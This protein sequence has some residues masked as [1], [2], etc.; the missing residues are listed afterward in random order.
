M[1]RDAPC[2]SGNMAFRRDVE[3]L[4]VDY[5]FARRHE[6]IHIARRV[7]ASVH[8]RGGR[9]LKLD[10]YVN[11]QEVYV[12]IELDRALHKASQ[13]LRERCFMDR[14]N[15]DN[16]EK[17]D[18]VV[19]A[20]GGRGNAEV[21]STLESTET[22]SMVPC[23]KRNS[24]DNSNAFDYSGESGKSDDSLE[25]EQW[26]YFDDAEPPPANTNVNM[27]PGAE[28]DMTETDTSSCSENHTGSFHPNA[29]FKDTSKKRAP[30]HRLMMNSS[31]AGSATKFA[32]SSTWLIDFF[33]HETSWEEM[34]LAVAD[35]KEV[36]GHCAIAPSSCSPGT[37]SSPGERAQA[38]L[39]DWASV[40]RQIF[41]EIHQGRR[42]A[43]EQ[44]RDR[45]ARLE[46]IGFV[47][48]YDEFHWTQR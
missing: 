24:K 39:A 38:R 25:E 48:D 17:L 1:L 3:N 46:R 30:V 21:V 12:E 41:R 34:F 32:T 18:Y 7:V 29:Y 40:Q 31:L 23:L 33:E 43:T 2:S 42:I 37:G 5:F 47:F 4:K 44:E 15:E 10:G 14:K 13:A 9:F 11:G 35:F 36:N 8:E 28:D 6:K 19:A 45:F 22:E 16:Q 20:C 27:K 26:A